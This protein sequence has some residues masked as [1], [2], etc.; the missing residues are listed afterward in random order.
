M[1]ATSAIPLPPPVGRQPCRPPRHPA[2]AACRRSLPTLSSSSR[3]SSAPIYDA[4]SPGAPPFVKVGD[5]VEPGQVLCIIE[6]MKLM[7]E[8][9]AEIAGTIVSKLV[10]NGQ[11]GRVRRGA[12]RR[13]PR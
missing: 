1:P 13:P 10:E 7:N 11:P 3:P 6:S 12:L 5:T 2:A 4:P 8:I 9:E